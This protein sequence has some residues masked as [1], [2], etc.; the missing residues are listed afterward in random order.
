[1]NP[2]PVAQIPPN[3][4]PILVSMIRPFTWKLHHGSSLCAWGLKCVTERRSEVE[5]EFSIASGF[6]K[7]SCAVWLAWAHRLHQYYSGS[8]HTRISDWDDTATGGIATTKECTASTQCYHWKT[9]E[10]RRWAKNRRA[11]TS[12]DR[13]SCTVADPVQ[14]TQTSSTGLPVRTDSNTNGLSNNIRDFE[15]TAASDRGTDS[16]TAV[17]N[18]SRNIDVEITINEEPATETTEN[19]TRHDCHQ[20]QCLFL[21]QYSTKHASTTDNDVKNSSWTKV[22]DNA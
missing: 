14:T 8:L 5:I 12:C 11:S 9:I 20:I 10:W 3:S 6:T 19:I 7:Y 4:N 22:D 13:G 1:M 15:S 21:N 2:V 17:A 18:L 16:L